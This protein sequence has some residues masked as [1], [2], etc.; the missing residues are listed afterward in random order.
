MDQGGSQVWKGIRG[1]TREAAYQNET[2]FALEATISP[3]P[4]GGAPRP[5]DTYEIEVEV[6]KRGL[7]PHVIE[8]SL[9]SGSTKVFESHVNTQGGKALQSDVCLKLPQ[10]V[11]VVVTPPPTATQPALPQI[12]DRL[13]GQP[14]YWPAFKRAMDAFA[15]MRFLDLAPDAM[16]IP[17]L[18]GQDIL[19][20]RGENLSSVLQ[21]ICTSAETK[22]AVL[23]WIRELTP[24][25]VTD[26]DFVPDQTG[27]ILVSLV[28]NG[29]KKI[30]AYSASDGT[31]RFLGMIA[32]MLGPKPARFYFIE[33]LENGIH[34]TRLH[35]LLQLIEQ[36]VADGQIQVVA[37]SHSPQL[38][39]FLSERSRANAS[40]L[41][42]LENQSDA[43]IRRIMDIPEA[44]HVLQQQDLARL[45]ASGWLEDVVAFQEGAGA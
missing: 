35:L 12:L 25:D 26:F 16:R 41:Y 11:D 7:P 20:D 42:R 8:E 30:S 24:L 36:K 2:T 31:L 27:K 44:A 39:G 3:L 45:H 9:S 40:L 37:T 18:I 1:G 19:G 4:D 10:R 5:P 43:R 14:E 21:A 34:P 29:G 6:G 13:S 17:S 32:A 38:L 15:S 23:E 33:K 22:A 28:E